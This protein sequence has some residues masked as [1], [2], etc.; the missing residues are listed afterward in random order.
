MEEE[1]EFL[2]IK[3]EVVKQ[4]PFCQPVIREAVFHSFD[5]LLEGLDD[6]KKVVENEDN[7]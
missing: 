2:D 3:I 5:E 6:F 4:K 1:K 7:N